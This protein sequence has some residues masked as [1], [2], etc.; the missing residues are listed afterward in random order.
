[1]SVRTY[2]SRSA[3]V[4][5]GVAAM[6]RFLE[7]GKRTAPDDFMGVGSNTPLVLQSMGLR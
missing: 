4:K 3:I 7:T 5:T 2:E 1:M 6:V